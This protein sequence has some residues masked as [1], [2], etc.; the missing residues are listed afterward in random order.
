[1][2]RHPSAQRLELFMSGELPAG[3]SPAIVRHLVAGCSECTKTTSHLWEVLVT[4]RGAPEAEPEEYE[5]AFDRAWA[6]A[7]KTHE[8]LRLERERAQALS[9]EL[10]KLPPPQQSLRVRNDRRFQTLA[11]CE[12]LIA[13]SEHSLFDDASAACNL[14]ELA[15]EISDNL[16]TRRYGAAI[17]ADARANAWSASANGLV[18]S[19][20]YEGAESAL[21]VAHSH[22]EE[23]TGSPTEKAKYLT[24]LATLLTEKGRADEALAIY[25]QLEG[26]YSK[27]G[28]QHMVGLLQLRKAFAF[29]KKHEPE[30]AIPLLT[31]ALELLDPARDPRRQVIALHN[32]TDALI[33][34]GRADEAAFHMIK[35]RQLYAEQGG[36]LSLLRFH[37]MEGRLAYAQGNL[38]LA[39]RLLSEVR[40][41]FIELEIG[42]DV[43][44]VSLD[45][46]EVLW[47]RGS[48][49]E[50]QRRLQEAIPILEALG[51]HAEALAAMAFL[52]HAVRVETASREL[53]RQTAAFVRRAHSDPTVR[54]SSTELTG[55]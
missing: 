33:D 17:V 35:L 55:R 34:A 46:A 29:F 7:Q 37:W 22:V 3:E 30:Y 47:H 15:C 2:S 53:I 31:R 12:A 23:G 28:D 44:L 20:D 52:E 27:L 38:D 24:S 42:I 41:T 39:Q 21:R 40:N 25:R 54:F 13:A 4:G 5:T 50:T 48:G 49:Q 9:S 18:T 19:S 43:A 6:G 45:L 11:L 10:L 51:V 8:L 16:D 36:R 26:I 1:M 14:A 32:L